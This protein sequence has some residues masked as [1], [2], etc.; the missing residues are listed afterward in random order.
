MHK[1]I[2]DQYLTDIPQEFADW[3]FSKV[4]QVRKESIH[5]KHIFTEIFVRKT[6]DIEKILTPIEFS[7]FDYMEYM[8]NRIR[9]IYKYPREFVCD[10]INLINSTDK[11]SFF[12]QLELYDNPHIA[13]DFDGVVTKNSFNKLYTLCVERAKTSIVSANPMITPNWF[14]KH[15]L[16][17]PHEIHSMKGKTK[18]MKKLIDL[19]NRCDKLFYIDDEEEYLTFAWVFGIQTYQYKNGKIVYFTLKS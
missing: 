6:I 3:G 12:P 18:K 1:N 4:L 16:P 17:L 11:N 13:L 10:D 5:I 7:I 9:R 19:A 14:E 2:N 8:T 15:D